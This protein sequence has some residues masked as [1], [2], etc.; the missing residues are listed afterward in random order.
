MI[1]I[2]YFEEWNSP[3]FYIKIQFLLQED[4]FG[5]DYEEQSV[6]IV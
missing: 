5:I 2:Q 4:T 1:S 3:K 6:Y